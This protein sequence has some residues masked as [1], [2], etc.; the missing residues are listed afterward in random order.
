MDAVVEVSCIRHTFEDG[1]TVEMCGLDFIVERGQR[2]AVLGPNGSGK[3][4]LL[5][6]V[7]G[8]LRPEEGRVRVLGVDP[9]A[10][11]PRIR[12]QIGVVLQDV[13]EQILAPTVWEDVSFSLRQYGHPAVEVARKTDEVME[14]VGVTRLRDKVP[15]HLSGGEKRKVA[16]AGALSLDPQLLIL[17][18]PLEGLDP[19]SRRH[20]VDVLNDYCAHADATMILTTHDINAVAEIADE[21]YVMATQ[22]GMVTRGK[23][24]EIFE[25]AGALDA[26]NIEPPILASLF[27][28]LRARTGTALPA[29]LSVKSAADALLAWKDEP[30]ADSP[31]GAATPSDRSSDKPDDRAGRDTL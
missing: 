5:F 18:E 15:H 30:V 11:F 4:T 26:S 21:V 13:D 7:L 14:L 20:T 27:T 24:S 3:S 6:H 1:T 12:E 8:L 31:D 28:E 22:G 23:P 9:A 16:L 17:D 29:A 10:D 19:K 25:R 2:V